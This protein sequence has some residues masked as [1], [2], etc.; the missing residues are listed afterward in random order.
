MKNP[1]QTFKI[2]IIYMYVHN[3]IS[4]IYLSQCILFLLN[5]RDWKLI[6]MN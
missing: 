4:N 1:Y 5:A 3:C 6:Q 2:I